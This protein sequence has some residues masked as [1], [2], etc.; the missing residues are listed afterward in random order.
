VTRRDRRYYKRYDQFRRASERALRETSTGD[1]RWTVIEGEDAR[2]RNVTMARHVLARIRTHLQARVAVRE[3]PPMVEPKT[4]PVTILDQLDLTQKVSGRAYENQLERWQGRL[5]RAAREAYAR[6]VGATLVFE[7][8][9]AAGK[10]GAI[11]RL[12][13]ALDA[14]QFRIIPIAAPTEEERAHHYLWRFWR[15]L[16]GPGRVTIYDRSWYGRVLVERVEGFANEAEWRRAYKEINDF[17]EQ[18]VESGMVLVKYWLHISGDEQL[19]RFK[20]REQIPWKRHKITEEDYRNREKSPLYEAAAD[21]MIGRTST[22]YAPW[23]LVEA[24]SK[25]FGR[26][27]VIKS[28]CKALEAAIRR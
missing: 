3:H 4:N 14:R 22:E 7:G 27:K 1:A 24:E 17:E 2:Y 13:P 6:G 12:I 28:F 25:H 9:D 15:H 21:E 11:R 20:E 16:P 8:W 5:A 18:L 19:R 10:G 23:T 26:I